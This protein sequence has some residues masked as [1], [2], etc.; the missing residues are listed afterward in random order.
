M[1]AKQ[2]LVH[3]SFCQKNAANVTFFHAAGENFDKQPQARTCRLAHGWRACH[4]A[5]MEGRDCCL[6]TQ[7]GLWVPQ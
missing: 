7:A 1:S 4:P 5:Q 2:N 3:V 6:N